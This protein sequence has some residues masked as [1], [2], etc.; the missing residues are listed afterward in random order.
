MRSSYGDRRPATATLK[1][2]SNQVRIV[3]GRHRGRKLRF[4]PSPGL[5]P[6]ADRVRETLF[7]WLQASVSGARCLDLFAGSGALGFEALSRGADHVVLVEQARKV[8]ERL[9]ENLATLGDTDRAEVVLSDAQRFLRRDDVPAFD[10]VFL[11]PPFAEGLLAE[12]VE[13]LERGGWLRSHACIYLEQDAAQP[14]LESPT[15]WHLHREGRAGQAAFRLY[16][17][18]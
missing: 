10:L 16:L 18:D 13:S 14:W 11:D 1:G 5:R 17:R 7:N 9:Q 6:T 15:R 12:I 2:G 8:A 3:G 4:V